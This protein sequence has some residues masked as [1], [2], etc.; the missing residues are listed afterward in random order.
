M[1][2][3]RALILGLVLLC[4]SAMVLAD[5]DE[6][7][8]SWVI[9]AN[10]SHTLSYGGSCSSSA[11]Y[12]IE[13]DASP[14]GSDTQLLPYDADSA[15]SPCQSVS[16][17]AI[18]ISNNGNVTT[19]VNASVTSTLETGVT[20]KLW[21]GS[22]GCGASGLG[23]YEGSCSKSGADDSN[24]PTT[25]ACVSIGDSSKQ[26]VADLAASGSQQLCLAADFSSLSQGTTTD[27]FQTSG[28]QSSG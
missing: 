9:P 27:T 23:G 21:L 3:L 26:I 20:L 24:V 16:V 11:M 12:F 2:A 13:D 4:L 22:S 19:D 25:A 15:G 10:V 5:T 17:A 7:T 1:R 6:T 18:T 14:D 28:Y 8:L